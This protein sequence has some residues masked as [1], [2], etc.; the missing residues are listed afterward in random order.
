[1]VKQC[2]YLFLFYP[3]TTNENELPFLKI[4]HKIPNEEHNADI[5]RNLNSE[6]RASVTEIY[7]LKGK[8]DNYT[9]QLRN[10]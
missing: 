5:I 10:K 6:I 2:C 9:L 8:I 3:K 4:T 1:M 7:D